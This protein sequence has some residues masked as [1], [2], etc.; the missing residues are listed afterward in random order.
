MNPTFREWVLSWKQTFD[1]DFL[2]HRGSVG[3]SSWCN[4]SISAGLN[5]KS[6]QVCLDSP[7]AALAIV[8]WLLSTSEASWFSPVRITASLFILL[9][10]PQRQN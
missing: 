8:H 3:E 1:S 4:P 5:D 10:V 9:C 7:R 2:Q 6:P